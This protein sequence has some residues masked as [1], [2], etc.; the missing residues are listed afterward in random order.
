MRRANVQ[1]GAMRGD[2]I[3]VT[4]GVASGD[5]IAT[6]GV[7]LLRDGQRVRDLVSKRSGG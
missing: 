5:R 2:N 3:L 4:D 7:T 6:A 1:V